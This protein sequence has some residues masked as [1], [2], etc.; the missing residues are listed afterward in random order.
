MKRAAGTRARQRLSESNNEREITTM[1]KEQGIRDKGQGTRRRRDAALRGVMVA[2][3]VSIRAGEHQGESGIVLAHQDGIVAI[4]LRNYQGAQGRV[5]VRE[6]QVS[7]RLMHAQDENGRIFD[8]WLRLRQMRQW[9]VVVL[10]KGEPKPSEAVLRTAER[11][12]ERLG[13]LRG[14]LK[15][16]SHEEMARICPSMARFCTSVVP[17]AGGDHE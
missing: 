7:F 5:I 17:Y 11:R 6:D 4:E 8:R 12:A 14:W 2:H 15:R 10:G 3:W 9:P 13:V 1:K 16:R